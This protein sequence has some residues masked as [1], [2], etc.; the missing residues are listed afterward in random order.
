MDNRMPVMNGYEATQAIRQREQS[1]QLTQPDSRPLP[2]KIISLTAGV[3][4]ANQTK[5]KQIGFDG[6]MGKP[7]QITDITRTI[8]QH[9]GVHYLYETEVAMAEAAS[10]PS[11][12]ELTAETLQTLS[13]D[14]VAQFQAALIYLDQE[15]MLGLI[16]DL[17]PK[18]A[19]IAQALS[20]RVEEFDYALLLT[21]IQSIQTR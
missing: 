7:I 21:L 10:P 14:W 1:F 9:L 18:Q 11:R 16:A 19:P 4:E 2:T 15:Q 12:S 20:Y 13:P 8:A 17:P 6:F 5:L 3:L